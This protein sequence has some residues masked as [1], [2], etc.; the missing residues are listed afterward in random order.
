[1]AAIRAITLWRNAGGSRLRLVLGRN[2]LQ[3]AS[4][5][6]AREMLS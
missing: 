2:R 4:E 6:L 1:L 3:Q 5:Q